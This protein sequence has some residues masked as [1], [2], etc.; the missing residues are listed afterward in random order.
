MTQPFYLAVVQNPSYVAMWG[1]V[2]GGLPQMWYKNVD[3]YGYVV[4][5]APMMWQ[6]TIDGYLVAIGDENLVLSAATDGTVTMATRLPV[7][8]AGAAAQR[9]SIRSAGIA[10]NP[11]QG[12]I[13]NQGNGQALSLPPPGEPGEGA[14]LWSGIN[15]QT[16]PLPS[17]TPPAYM[18]WLIQPCTPPIGQTFAL[19]SVGAS[20]AD[21]MM[22]ANIPASNAIPGTPTIIYQAA[23]NAANALWRYTAEGFILSAMMPD[24]A[25]SASVNGS[26]GYGTGVATYPQQPTGQLS[27]ASV[28]FQQWAISPV[29][30]KT[31]VFVIVN[32]AT[33]QALAVS[34]NDNRDTLVLVAL[35]VTDTAQQWTLSPTY[36]LD[37]LLAQPTVAYPT[38][39]GD[40]ATAYGFI[41][42]MLGL[43]GS[44]G[45]LRTQYQNMAAP[46]AS[47]QNTVNFI[48]A[49]G[50]GPNATIGG[51]APPSLSPQVWADVAYQLNRELTD[52]QAVQSL[53]QQ[54]TMFHT[55]FSI[56]MTNAVAK[57]AADTTISTSAPITTKLS[58][59]TLMESLVY[60]A[61]SA[62]STLSGFG[63]VGAIVGNLMPVIANLYQTGLNTGNAYQQSKAKNAQKMA[64]Q[65]RWDQ[66]EGAVSDLQQFL[67]ES[68]EV[69]GGGLA[70]VEAAIL[71]DQQKTMAVAAMTRRTGT[72]D[73]LYWSLDQAPLLID[74]FLPGFEVAVMQVLLPSVYKIY[75]YGWQSA[76]TYYPSDCPDY[77]TW[78][79]ALGPYD[80]EYMYYNCYWIA[81]QKSSTD[82]PSQ[83]AMQGDL[84]NNGAYHRNLFLRWG[85]WSNFDLQEEALNTG[86]TI[87]VQFVN[88]SPNTL[89]IAM[90]PYGSE[91]S[92]IGPYWGQDFASMD[93]TLPPYGVSSMVVTHDAKK[94]TPQAQIIVTNGGTQIFKGVAQSGGWQ[95]Q[96]WSGGYSMYLGSQPASGSE[97]GTATARIGFYAP[98]G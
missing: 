11:E 27:P 38:F 56:V 2:A 47:Y 6:V 23:A 86:T 98:P 18:L 17:G 35:D 79:E 10:A 91:N 3:N 72:G 22:V 21:Q 4:P 25:L 82:F 8:N 68:F 75:R 33:A 85:G 63:A 70:A 64:D 40:A 73:S 19:Q 32:Q 42:Q 31:G 7:S 95:S 24:L 83:Q 93:I 58:I 36:P 5:E 20:T 87:I 44:A 16:L 45:D 76:D 92:T 60:T 74:R 80:G 12:V 15:P 62:A 29:D 90:T 61:L 30:R 53:F 89:S 43:T 97:G 39:S 49:N 57:L 88:F 46:L 41:N 48:A 51:Q 55:Q 66:F 14:N 37:V 71:A 34:G 59:A 67:I 65:E 84:W 28:T 9:W 13:V 54:V 94:D 77:C 26:G 81:S 69:I 50:G 1:S 96:N 52:V 78:A